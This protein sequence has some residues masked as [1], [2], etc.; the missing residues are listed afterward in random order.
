[1]TKHT[2]QKFLIAVFLI[3]PLCLAVSCF[4]YPPEIRYSDNL[5]PKLKSDDPSY[6]LDDETKAYSYDLGGTDISVRYVKTSE[7]NA[8][9]LEESKNGE[10]STNPYT[11]GN[12][13]DPDLGYTPNR[14]TVLEVSI[15][16]RSF[17]KMMLDPREC[18]LITDL[19][20]VFHTY[21][22]SVAAAKYGTSFED[23]FKTRRGQSGNEF[24]RYEMRLG[25][26]RGK[27]YSLDQM[28]FRGDT[29]TGLIAFEP[30]RPEV[31]KV[32]LTLKDVVYRFDAFNRPSDVVT[33]SFDFDRV[34][35]K[36][37]VTREMRLAELEKEKVKIVM[38]GPR[39]MVDNRINDSA[40][41][42]RAIDRGLEQA[43]VGME[44][45]FND[46]YRNNEVK[47]G[48]M[49][50]SFTIEPDGVVSSQNVIEVTG[51]ESEDFM[52]CVLENVKKITFT[53][54][55]DLPNEGTNIVKGPAKPVNVI[56]PLDFTIT[57]TE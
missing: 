40:R 49:V 34:I 28:I 16:N 52:N 50:I 3:L 24:Y 26:V 56:Y 13:I 25:M 44:K 14:F 2:K 42:D 1:M 32:R 39:Q 47:P 11:Y 10:Y 8:M 20:E 57:K 48:N 53:P 23:Y 7:L 36:Q 5:V 51:I 21:T 54:I 19:G 22:T 12:W 4:L 45:C 35:E 30:L 41:N 6:K 17:T 27:N 33:V 46:R 15:V 18:L 29:Y 9:F 37:V 31:K 43:R 55:E 38:P